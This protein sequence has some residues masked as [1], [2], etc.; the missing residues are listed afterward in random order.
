VK[1]G[2]KNGQPDRLSSPG[3][4]DEADE[5]A[6]DEGLDWLPSDEELEKLSAE[7]DRGWDLIESGES[8]SLDEAR[9]LAEDLMKRYPEA[10]EVLVLVGML[11]SLE[12]NV[13]QALSRYEQASELDPEYFEP[14][15]CAAE[16]YIWELGED[17]KGLKLCQKAQEVAEEEEEYLDAVLLHAEAEINLGREKAAVSTLRQIPD[18]DLP[19]PRYHVRVGRLFLDLGQV[20]EAEQ[21]LKNALEHDDTSGDALH[22]LGLCAERRGKHDEMVAYYRRVRQADLKEPRPPWAMSEESFKKTCAEALDRLPK[23]LRERMG[24]VPVIATDYPSE[25]LIADGSD[26]RMLGLFAGVPFG[27]KSSVGGAPHLDAIFL[28]QRNI[29]RMAYTPDDIEHEIEITLVHEAGHFFGF[30]DEQLDAMGLG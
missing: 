30:S 25:E 11:D 4:K 18:V 16:L 13:E 26:P 9:R 27:D 12:G 24:N 2:L 23:P 29:E 20:R 1:T 3:E 17:E 14:L 10:P 5:L 6:G 28:F 21:H 22:G 15:L 8:G 19:E 7:L